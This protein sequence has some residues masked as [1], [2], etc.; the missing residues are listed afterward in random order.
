MMDIQRVEPAIQALPARRTPL[1][2]HVDVLVC[3]GGVAGVAAA[4]AAAR[5]G[6]ST[7][8]IEKNVVL[9]GSGATA[10]ANLI[11]RPTGGI[12]AEIVER[13]MK[14]GQAEPDESGNERLSFDPEGFKYVCLDLV[15][16]A[17]VSL[18][19][20][21]WVSDP[22]QVGNAVGGAMVENKSGRFAIPAKSVVDATGDG[23][24]ALRA[25]APMCED[26]PN[27]LAINARIGGI[28]FDRALAGKDRW[29]S[30]ISDAK[31]SGVLAEI[32]PDTIEL[33]GITATTRARR[34]AF[35]RG[36]VF[37]DR[38]A[39]D[40]RQVS[41]SEMEGRKLMRAYLQFLRTI[42]GF[43]DCFLV[44]VAG[45]VAGQGR[46]RLA[47][48]T[49]PEWHDALTHGLAG[50][51]A[52]GN[53]ERFQDLLTTPE[54]PGLF[55]VGGASAVTSE[56]GAGGAWIAHANFAQMTGAAIAR[57]VRTPA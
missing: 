28:D 29:R 21:S 40:A 22:I 54:V 46:R 36:P 13:L 16:E 32:M 41:R 48:E 45:V 44:D 55:V 50:L 42:P 18:L 12:G 2:R 7:L 26:G 6:A 25:H 15:R 31:R 20:S 33:Y 38:A 17:G 3:G 34:M 43:E 8:L 14:G 47:R 11:D 51:D 27:S 39:W 53:F 49:R 23:E 52:E 10:F 30:L 57:G 35:L 24:F 9:G 5:A 56:S 4:V 37:Q 1:Y 19:L